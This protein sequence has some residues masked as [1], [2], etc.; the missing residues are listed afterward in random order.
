MA[1]TVDSSGAAEVGRLVD[2]GEIVSL[3]AMLVVTLSAEMVLLSA[4]TAK[5]FFSEKAKSYRLKHGISCRPTTIR[6]K[7]TT[8]AP[9]NHIITLCKQGTASLNYQ[10]KSYATISNGGTENSKYSSYR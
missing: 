8:R 3:I 10:N 5:S 4:Q 7:Y 1:K 2:E 6:T 9:N